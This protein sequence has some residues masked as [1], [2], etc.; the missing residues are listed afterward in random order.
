MAQKKKET[1]PQKRK[2][3]DKDTATF[4]SMNSMKAKPLLSFLASSMGMTKP[5]TYILVSLVV[6]H[7]SGLVELVA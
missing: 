3:K 1:W 5:L 7:F 4:L 2:D 6:I